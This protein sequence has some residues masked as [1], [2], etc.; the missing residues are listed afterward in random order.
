MSLGGTPFAMDIPSSR[1]EP[2]GSLGGDM[3]KT[4][5]HRSAGNPQKSATLTSPWF[6]CNN[7]LNPAEPATS[8]AG[9]ANQGR[10]MAKQRAAIYLRVSTTDRQTTENQRIALAQ[11]AEAPSCSILKAI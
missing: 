1:V 6:L 7:H 2:H 9:L 11:V 4:A 5:L 10:A 3:Q 8:S